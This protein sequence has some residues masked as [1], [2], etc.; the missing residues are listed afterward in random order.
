M[1]LRHMAREKRFSSLQFTR[2]MDLIGLGE[3]EKISKA[4][5]LRL[6]ST[7]REKLMSPAYFDPRFDIEHEL[8]TNPDTKSTY[9]SYFA[10][11]SEDLKWSKWLDPAIAEDQVLYAAEVSKMAKTMINRLIVSDAIQTWSLLTNPTGI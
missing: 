4:E 6:V 8:D 3:G 9:D 2:L 11:I 5:Y 1:Q 7:C 10:R